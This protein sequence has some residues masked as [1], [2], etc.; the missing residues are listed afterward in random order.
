MG[1]SCLPGPSN[2]A[3]DHS[4]YEFEASNFTADYTVY[5]ANVTALDACPEMATLG[6]LG[7]VQ[8]FRLDNPQSL[9]ALVK[10]SA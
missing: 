9:G 3:H 4:V 1:F 10:L 5:R 2:S 6:R 8:V 7:R